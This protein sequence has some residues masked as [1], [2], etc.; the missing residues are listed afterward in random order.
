[1]SSG[2]YEWK[3]GDKPPLIGAH[4]LAKHEVLARYITRYMQV[5]TR[6]PTKDG[7]KITLVDGFAG[8]GRYTREDTGASHPGSPLLMMQAMKEAE[9]EIAGRRRRPFKLD[10]RFVFVEKS[11]QNAAF[12]RNVL[13]EEGHANR[14]DVAIIEGTFQDKVQEI[15]ADIRGRGRV[16]R[17]IFVLD[18]YGYKDVVLATI[19]DIFAKLPQAEVVLTFATDWLIDPLADTPLHAKALAGLGITP[20]QLLEHKD[21]PAWRRAIELELHGHLQAQT[22]AKFYTP[23]FVVSPDAHR[24]YWLVH[25]SG[26]AK[27]RDVMT[28]LHWEIHNHFAHYAGVGLDMFRQPMLGYSPTLDPSVTGQAYLFDSSARALTEAQLMEDIPRWL[29]A[30][31]SGVT[32]NEFFAENVNGTA[33]SSDI[34]KAALV[35]LVDVSEVEIFGP[36]GGTR[37]RQDQVGD[38]DRLRLKKQITLFRGR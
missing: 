1:M 35:R 29:Q 2:H 30:R 16:G 15:I 12:L 25:L 19:R 7:I 17:S 5:R 36:E 23:F 20:A 6:N 27:A 24:S 31:P 28:Q 37:R 14:D 8:G 21:G 33:A 18:Q 22:G 26:H 10:A 34:L 9:A 4:S 32:F 3:L 38:T 13:R 11:P